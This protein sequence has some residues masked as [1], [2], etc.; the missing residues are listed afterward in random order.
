LPTL[1]E[2]S[3]QIEEAFERFVAWLGQMGEIKAIFVFG[4]ERSIFSRRVDFQRMKWFP[5][6]CPKIKD[7]D[8]KKGYRFEIDP[9]E[10]RERDTSDENIIRLWGVLND[11]SSS[12]EVLCIASG[13]I[14]FVPMARETLRRGKKIAIAAIEGIPFS[15]ELQEVA[16]ADPET[17]KP[18]IHYFYPV[19]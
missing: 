18:M 5:V 6:L 8:A 14:D 3:F 16:S 10:G 15:R 1:T 4:S 19:K 12:W 13:D 7:Y 9:G 11:M 2:K 17:G